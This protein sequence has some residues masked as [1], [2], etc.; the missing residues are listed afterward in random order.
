MSA[1]ASITACLAGLKGSAYLKR[2]IENG[3]P[4]SRVV[5]YEQ[6]GDKSQSFAEIRRL[7]LDAG[8]EFEVSRS[9]R[10]SATD[11]V[12]VVG[13]QFLFSDVTPSTIVFH[14]SLLPRFRGFAPTVSALIRG[15]SHIG[16]TALLPTDEVDA[17][18]IVLQASFEVEYPLSIFAALTRQAVLMADMSSEIYASWVSGRLVAAEQDASKATYSIWR[19]EVDFFIDWSQSS[20]EIVRFINAVGFPYDCA[21]TNLNNDCLRITAAT[22]VRDL[23]F[24][25]RQPGKIWSIENHKPVVVCGQGMIRLDEYAS[26]NGKTD[27]VKKLRSRLQ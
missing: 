3:L 14:D 2:A 13:W 15:E 5:S 11:L 20:D 12:F 10:F 7:T 19:D 6:S 24:E 27:L 18:P 9:P 17:G 16:A 1:P 26:I 22:V 23:E 8:L 21:K 25:I 4:V